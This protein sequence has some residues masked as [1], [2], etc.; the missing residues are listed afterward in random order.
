MTNAKDVEGSYSRSKVDQ[1][2]LP[3]HELHV[4]SRLNHFQLLLG[5]NKT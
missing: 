4:A 3:G 5:I 1:S 2:K